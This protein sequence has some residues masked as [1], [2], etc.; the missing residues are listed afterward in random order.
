MKNTLLTTLTIAALSYSSLTSAT[1]LTTADD[2]YNSSDSESNSL[3]NFI[4]DTATTITIKKKLLADDRI[5][6]LNIRVITTNAKVTLIGTVPNEEAKQIA[7][8]IAK[9]TKGVVELEADLDIT[10]ESLMKKASSDSIITSK[11]K[12]SYLDDPDINS[13]NISVRTINGHVSLKG[14][15]S[16]EDTKKKL[17]DIAKNTYGVKQVDADIKIDKS[18]FVKNI[19]SDSAITSAIKLNY[20]EDSV[21]SVLDIHVKTINKEVTLSGAVLTEEEK[22]RAIAIAKLTHGVKKVNSELKL[23]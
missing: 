18:S 16:N 19:A 17:I 10:S 23:K 2:H 1:V 11:I 13:S 9:S 6:S 8:S 4:S 20:L 7:I 22:E 3:K 21:L 12:L 15:A 5:N 14:I